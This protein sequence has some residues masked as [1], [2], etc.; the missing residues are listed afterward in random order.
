MARL[1]EAPQHR[2][3]YASSRAR[4]AR[5][6]GRDRPLPRATPRGLAPPAPRPPT[7]A[8]LAWATCLSFAKAEIHRQARSS[9]R[10]RPSPRTEEDVS[11]PTAGGTRLAPSSPRS[12][13]AM[14]CAT[15]AATS[16][17]CWASQLATSL[18]AHVRAITVARPFVQLE[19]QHERQQLRWVA[20]VGGRAP[21]WARAHR[22]RACEAASGEVTAVSTGPL[23]G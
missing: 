23:R 7:W 10:K 19:G 6:R 16:H 14:A 2:S 8:A 12:R 22:G 4:R 13:S 1:R 3:W 21:T 5:T 15:T 18:R 11:R 9:P 17:S 20:A